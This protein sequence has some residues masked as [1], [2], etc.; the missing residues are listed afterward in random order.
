MNSRRLQVSSTALLFVGGVVVAW[1][2]VLGL[3][4][5]LVQVGVNHLPL[6]LLGE[7]VLTWGLLLGFAAAQGR[8][9]E[10]AVVLGSGLAALLLLGLAYAEL[11]LQQPE[12]A[13]G[14]ALYA[15]R[16]I[17]RAL[18]LHAL[19]ETLLPYFDPHK[20]PAPASLL[21]AATAGMGL[22]GLSLVIL[23][24]TWQPGDLILLWMGGVLLALVGLGVFL[25]ENG[26]LPRHTPG[27]PPCTSGP[28]V[29]ATCRPGSAKPLYWQPCCSARYW[30][31]C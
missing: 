2:E 11:Q 16:V 6:A 15:A 1:A 7:A 3:A 30:P 9:P 21:P 24:A 12:A 29:C 13:V 23:C 20:V 26:H 14:A 5:F 4:L 22:G 19:W 31:G 28:C 27:K 25:D 17:L 18:L 10:S 8:L